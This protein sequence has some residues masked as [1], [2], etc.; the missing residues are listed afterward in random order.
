[1]MGMQLAQFHRL[2]RLSGFSCPSGRLVSNSRLSCPAQTDV[3]WSGANRC[4][5]PPRNPAHLMNK[6]TA[7]ASCTSRAKLVDCTMFQFFFPFPLATCCPHTKDIPT[8]RVSPLGEFPAL[9]RSLRLYLRVVGSFA[10]RLRFDRRR[11]L[12]HLLRAETD[13]PSTESF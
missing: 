10:A 9:W 2:K 13:A 6:K 5:T 7:T 12:N 11:I 8:S 1:M 3:V 4:E